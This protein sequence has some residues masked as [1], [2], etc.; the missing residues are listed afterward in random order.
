LNGT[1]QLLVYPGDVNLLGE[2]IHDIETNTTALLIA[3]KETSLEVNAEKTKYIFM[4]LD[5]NA[6]QT[7]NVKVS[8]KSL[9]IVAHLKYVGTKPRNQNRMRGKINSR[10]N[11]G[12][13]CYDSPIILCVPACEF[14]RLSR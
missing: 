2:N 13:P 10:L 4:S 12:Y 3:S 7:H 6:L 14:A 1:Y 5:H 8:V 11:S 9:E